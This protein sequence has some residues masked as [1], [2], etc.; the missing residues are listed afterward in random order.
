MEL[1]RLLTRANALLLQG[2]YQGAEYFI[3][4]AMAESDKLK[5]E[6][7]ELD[8]L[9]TRVTE[10]AA[11]VE[12]LQSHIPEWL[13]D[14]CN[15]VHVAPKN[16]TDT[17]CKCGNS[18]RPSSLTERRLEAENSRLQS[19]IDEANAQEHVY[20]WRE[21]GESDWI[22]C[23]KDWYY[24]CADSA[25]HDTKMLYTRPIPAQQS[26]AVA[27]PEL[28][29]RLELAE[30]MIGTNGLKPWMLMISEGKSKHFV[31]CS[32][33]THNLLQEVQAGSTHN[34]RNAKTRANKN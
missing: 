23:H 12:R 9:R 10:M 30:M 17:F 1:K 22:Q 32:E 8:T 28:L 16:L 13:C 21:I 27:V 14:K 25:E 18:L 26:P 5:S 31:Y 24:K 34:R 19:V 3:E 6:L 20:F 15:C 4:Q 2:A 33:R 29:E 7:A 11:E